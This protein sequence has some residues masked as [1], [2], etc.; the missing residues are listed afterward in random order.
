MVESMLA[1]PDARFFVAM[2]HDEVAAVGCINGTNEIAL[3]YVSP[4][5]RLSGVSKALL[6]EM[7][8]QLR[9]DGVTTAYLTSTGT[10]RRFYLA[11]G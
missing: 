7:E 6:A 11:A 5:H 9:A 10:A 3:N 4:R 8:R 1:D 2:R